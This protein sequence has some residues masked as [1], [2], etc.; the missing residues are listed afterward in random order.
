MVEAAERELGWA[1]QLA[2]LLQL[3][4]RELSSRGTLL[5]PAASSP[6]LAAAPCWNPNFPGMENK[7]SR[8]AVPRFWKRESNQADVSL[9]HTF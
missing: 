9:E 4:A 3:P 1:S 6:Q 2:L 7:A 8:K 5:S